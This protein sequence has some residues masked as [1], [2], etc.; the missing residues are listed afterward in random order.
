MVEFR[1]ADD[2]H[3]PFENNIFDAIIGEAI[4][5]FVK[6]KQKAVNE[7]TR[8]VKPGGYIGLNEPT[9]IKTPPQISLNIILASQV[10]N[11][12]PPITGKKS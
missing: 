2:Q 5:T 8:V 1:V 11:Q 12:N 4:I 3:L 7:C 9:W 6:N 10:Q